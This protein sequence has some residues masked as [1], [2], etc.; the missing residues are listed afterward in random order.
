MKNRRTFVFAFAFLF[1]LCFPLNAA[2]QTADDTG[3]KKSEKYEERTSEFNFRNSLAGT[4]DIAVTS[5]GA[6][7]FRAMITFMESGGLIASSQGDILLNIN[8][9]ATPGHGA[10]VR[11]GNRAFLFTFRQIFYG[12][13]GSYE[14]GILV[15]HTANM[16]ANG[17]NWT[18]DMTFEI[19]NENDVV[20]FAGTGSGTATR[21]NPLPLSQ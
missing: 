3:G 17:Q 16:T 13:D 14:G 5:S 20:V 9:V 7:P 18:G 10:W 11:T 8:S 6:P 21:L 2:A 4:W 12:A 15:R 1:A 19:Y